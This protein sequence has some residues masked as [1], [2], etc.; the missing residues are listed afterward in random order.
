MLHCS[1]RSLELRAHHDC[2]IVGIVAAGVASPMTRLADVVAN[3]SPETLQGV[4]IGVVLQVG[5][6]EMQGVLRPKGDEANG[7]PSLDALN[8]QT[9]T[10]G[11][12]V[13][14]LAD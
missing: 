9:T 10:R 3:Y 8:D 4:A 2:H 13:G 5:L 11:G 1:C 6:A 12:S 14:S 7:R